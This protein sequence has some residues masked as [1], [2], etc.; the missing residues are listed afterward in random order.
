MCARPSCV[1]NAQTLGK[2]GE[3]LLEISTIF[4]STSK[5]HFLIISCVGL[6]RSSMDLWV[7]FLSRLWVVSTFHVMAKQATKPVGRPSV[8][9]RS[10]LAVKYVRKFSFFC[11]HCVVWAQCKPRRE[12]PVQVLL[13]T[14]EGKG[15]VGKDRRHDAH[16]QRAQAQ[17]IWVGRWRL[18][19]RSGTTRGAAGRARC[20]LRPSGE[21]LQ[22]W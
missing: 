3:N 7:L 4:A 21:R 13:S 9:A 15:V 16:P 6:L 14:S 2:N 18:W 5:V 11:A 17:K 22:A 10:T 19:P 12:A 20:Q 1:S 8:D